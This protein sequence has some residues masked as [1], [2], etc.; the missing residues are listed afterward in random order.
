MTRSNKKE[1]PK[2][3]ILG[4]GITDASEQQILEY[5]INST[6]NFTNK[7]YITTP[8]PEML[9]RA[10]AQKS[11]KTLLNNA[12]LALCDG[13]GVFLAAK[14]L[15]KPLKARV[16]GTDLVESLCKAVSSRAVTV[17]F[18]G[19]GPKVAEQ[20][21]EC[22]KQKYPNLSV[23]FIGRDISDLDV[24]PA[25]AIPRPTSSLTPFTAGAR[26]GSPGHVTHSPPVSP[27]SNLSHNTKYII[28]NTDILFVAYGFPKQEEFMTEHLE[29]L[30]VKVMMGVGGA[31]DYI[32]GKVPRAP[33]W[34]RSV[35]LE[36]LFR[37][38]IQP[39]RI[40]R[41]VALVIFIWLV[42]LERFKSITKK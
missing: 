39:W 31:F 37:L 8:N 36:W 13:T 20:A 25:V 32:S 38:T 24:G 26:R 40:K 1:L 9:V 19:A 21:A 6:E 41:Q 11:L 7:Y 3:N 30:P 12:T 34:V 22:L 35:G 10:H 4:I 27:A 29:K 15:G 23:S 18:L 17:G 16:T 33:Q 28:P 42:L 14:I 5:I 2:K